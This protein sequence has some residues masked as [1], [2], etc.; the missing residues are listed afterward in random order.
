MSEQHLDDDVRVPED[1]VLIKIKD[2]RREVGSEVLEAML[3]RL[4]DEARSSRDAVS[5][6][7]SAV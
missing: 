1:L 7:Q 5:G 4:L 2:L 3:Q 6:F